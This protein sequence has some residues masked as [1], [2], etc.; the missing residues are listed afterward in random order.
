MLG[1][2]PALLSSLQARMRTPGSLGAALTEACRDL[3]LDEGEAVSPVC[4]GY[5]LLKAGARPEEVSRLLSWKDFELL[6]GALLKASGY[7]VR[8]NVV[9]TK[10]R[11]QLDIVATGTSLTLSV[12]CKH[13]RRSHSPSSLEKFARDQLRRSELLRKKAQVRGSIAS[14]ILSM[15]EP[16]G[17]FVGGVAVVPIRTLRSFLNSVESY[18][19]ALELR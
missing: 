17:R 7:S 16:E 19:G 12:D 4:A 9:L 13:Y 15:S 6:S 8:E 10:P 5:A 2:S 3:E 11:A 18:L 1:T 14:V